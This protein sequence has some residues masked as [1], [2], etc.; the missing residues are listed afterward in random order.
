MLMTTLLQPVNDI[1]GSDWSSFC[2]FGASA[3]IAVVLAGIP[4]VVELS[5]SETDL[6]CSSDVH[7]YAPTPSKLRWP[8]HSVI[9]CS[10]A[11]L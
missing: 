9:S 4:L 8:V 3:C 2:F 10:A 1:G 7:L 11:P 6:C 5:I